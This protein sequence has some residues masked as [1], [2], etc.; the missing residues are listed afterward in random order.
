[1]AKS[2]NAAKQIERLREHIRRHEYLYYVLDEPEISDIKFDQMMKELQRLEAAHAELVTPD[3]PSQRVGGAPRKGVET[4]Q[5]SP[6]M[7]SLDNTYSTEDL[8]EFDRR[9]RELSGRSRIDYVAEHKFDGLSISL[10]YEGGVLTRGVTR[11]DGT[12]GEDGT[13]NVRT[14][15]SIPLRVDPAERRKMHLPANF[16]VTGEIIMHLRDFVELNKRYD[17]QD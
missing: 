7:M 8:E 2:T 4:R 17:G 10:V 9:V 12:C 1:M 11:G 3:S 15:R 6:A 16:A 13:P 5:H 14:I